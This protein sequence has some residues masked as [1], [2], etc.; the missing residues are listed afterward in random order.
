MKMASIE[1]MKDTLIDNEIDYIKSMVF[2]DKYEDLV[3]YVYTNHF[4]GFKSMS[5]EEIKELYD[6]QQ[7]EE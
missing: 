4:S 7:G 5:Q 2:Q 6:F 3:E 1:K